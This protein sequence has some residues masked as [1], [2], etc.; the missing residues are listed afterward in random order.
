[1]L[2]LLN[3]SPVQ[4][5]IAQKITAS[6][7]KKIGTQ[8]SIRKVFIS[9]F[10]KINIEGVLIRD[11]NTDTLL[12]ANLCKI[13][14]TDWFFL[15]ENATL[16]YIGIEDAVV[17]IN[18]KTKKWNYDFITTYFNSN[19]S[20]SKSGRTQYDIK[21]IDLKSIR[22]EQND[23]WTGSYMKASVVS[24]VADCKK[25]NSATGFIKL[26]TVSLDQPS[27]VM[28]V[29]PALQ[30]KGAKETNTP[31]TTTNP[32]NINA[33]E[34]TINKGSLAIDSDLEKP[35]PNF[36]G[37]HL[38]F[39]SINASIKN[40]F[41]SEKEIKAGI[42]LSAKERS[43][44][45]VKK[46]NTSFT[47]NPNIMEFAN[48]DLQTN[49]S[50]IGNY[51]AMKFKN[52]DQDFSNYISNVVMIANIKESTVHT[53]DIAFFAPA[54]SMFKTKALLSGNYKGTVEDFTV[55]QLQLR[56]G[57]NSVL[58]GTFSMK[59]LPAIETTQIT[60]EQGFAQSNYKDLAQFIP[61]IQNIKSPNIAAL[62]TVLYRGDFRGTAF[63]FVTKGVFSTALGG[64]NTDI[65]L[66]LPQEGEASYKGSL[67][68][69]AFNLGKFTN[70]TNLGAID[71][72]GSIEGSS[73][74]IEKLKISIS[75][76][77]R[78][79]EYKKYNYK[80]IVTN[81]TFQKKYFSG[82]IIINDPN[83]NFTSSVEI[84]FNQNIPAFN[85]VGDLAY[86]NLKALKLYPTFIEVTGLLD[87]NFTGSNLDNFI[88]NA[89]F[90]NANINDST[91]KLN[92]YSLAVQS[93]M[94][95]KEKINY[96][97]KQRL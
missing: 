87:A 20:T 36:D 67:E 8:V 69:I 33:D 40:V 78:A 63:D 4:N 81:G 94:V 24:L 91:T 45:V 96:A 44:L 53:D 19:D 93:S 56:T 49:R 73:F 17:K 30:P 79:I 32:L 27:F 60:L 43:G 72:K 62:G 34:I 76:D 52:F 31:A 92:F 23:Q 90:L 70:N 16:S 22:F 25:I 13:R 26:G 95:G 89:K 42:A 9:P 75:G 29:I 18:R 15:K 85:I 38:N 64:I 71:F 80:S 55:N 2:L 83:L 14:I 28:K 37:T 5:Y 35:Y 77:I 47:L 39:F 82:D 59:G 57:T 97:K 61:T 66:K 41:V 3:T 68:T 21:K 58:T 86:S 51:Y 46:L 54:M 11:Q 6:I 84:N 1:M 10:N 65:N 88:G 74:D 50:R 12:F 48:L 7:S